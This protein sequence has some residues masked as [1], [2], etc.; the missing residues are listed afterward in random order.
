MQRGNQSGYQVVVWPAGRDLAIDDLWR[1]F[2]ELVLGSYLVNTSFDSG[3]LMLSEPEKKKGWHLVGR[4]AHSPK[5]QHVDEIP[6]DQFD[7]WLI[8]DQ[9]VEVRE[10]ETM[11]NYC[12]FSPLDFWEEKRD[13]FWAQIERLQ[14][15]HVIGENDGAYL[16]TRDADLFRR[17]VEAQW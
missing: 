6:H 16:V 11:V 14:P 13:Q 8:F 5:I 12:D 9:A 17:I 1:R 2:P 10:F 3:F 4:L 7:E 15:V